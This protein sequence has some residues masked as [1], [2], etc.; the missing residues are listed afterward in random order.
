MENQI[1]E[2][3]LDILVLVFQNSIFVYPDAGIEVNTRFS[4]KV[5][6]ISSFLS[7]IQMP[8]FTKRGEP[9]DSPPGV[10]YALCVSLS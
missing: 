7:S 4:H 6:S 1:L 9:F 3:L 5:H 10:S 2:C 8:I